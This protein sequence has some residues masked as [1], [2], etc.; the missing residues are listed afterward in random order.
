MVSLDDARNARVMRRE[1]SDDRI[2]EI[3][4]SGL[5]QGRRVIQHDRAG[6]LR[7]DGRERRRT[8]IRRSDTVEK[9]EL[10]RVGKHDLRELRPVERTVFVSHAA[11]RRVQCVQHFAAFR[12]ESAVDRVR[13]H[14]ACAERAHACRNRALSR[15][16]AAGQSDDFHLFHFHCSTYGLK[17]SYKSMVYLINQLN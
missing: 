1:H 10:F 13:V 8:D 9:R 15:T 3:V 12:T 2:A 4:R 14:P 17:T 16:A 6:T 11:E 5:E 7:T